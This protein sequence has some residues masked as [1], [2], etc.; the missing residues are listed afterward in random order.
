MT[1]KLL[2]LLLL[3]GP[4]VAQ[5]TE[6][7][8]RGGLGL[9]RYGG[10][11]A[12]ATSFVNYSN[13]P[14]AE[15]GYTNSPYGSGWGTGFSLGGRVQRVTRHRALL[16][17]DLGYDWLRSRTTITS[18]NYSAGYNTQQYVAEGTT[19]LRTS[20][21]TAYLGLGYRVQLPLVALDILAGPELAGILSTREQGRGTYAGSAGSAAW[22]TASDRGSSFPVDARLRADL[23]AWYQRLGLLA[24]YSHGFLNYQAGLVGGPV[25]SAYG[26]TLRL[27]LAYRPR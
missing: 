21:V 11:D 4:A 23:T 7:I 26:R 17:F 12:Q 8:G 16:A 10:N 24:S 13:F 2:P 22:A 6:L 9:F 25:R 19:H 1:K 18:L 3:A 20:S 27:G 15:G 5:R 14:G